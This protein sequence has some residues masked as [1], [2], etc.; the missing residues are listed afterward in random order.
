LFFLRRLEECVLNQIQNN[1]AEQLQWFHYDTMYGV[2]GVLYFLLDTN[3]ANKEVIVELINYIVEIADEKKYNGCIISGFHIEYE[4]QYTE[5]IKRKYPKGHIN[6]GMAHG[7]LGPAM[8]LAKAIQKGYTN[9]KIQRVVQNILELYN[10]FST[11]DNDVIKF[12]TMLSFEDYIKG[13]SSTNTFNVGWCYGNSSIL[14]GLMKISKYLNMNELYKYYSMELLKVINQPDTYYNLHSPIVC[15]GYASIVSMQI[16]A[17]IET[18][19]ERYLNTLNRNVRK[20]LQEHEKLVMENDKEYIGNYNL[21]IGEGGVLMTLKNA[22]KL[23]GEYVR[24]LL[25]D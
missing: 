3:E 12:P 18:N 1:K 16:C 20:M 21:W 8:V 2:S 25:I 22:M 4:Q 5:N 9:E 24:V 10:E 14:R 23:N 15:H 13:E 6:F 17:Y 11:I 19:D 7:M